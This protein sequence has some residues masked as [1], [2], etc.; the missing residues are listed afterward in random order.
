MASDVRY[1]ILIDGRPDADLTAELV[2][3]EVTESVSEATTARVR[4]AVDVCK[5]DLHFLDDSRLAP[6]VDR[7]LSVLVSVDGQSHIIAHGPIIDRKVKLL[8][9]GPGSW[10][11]V[12]A[13]DRRAVM[14]RG[15]RGE[16]TRSGPVFV[17]VQSILL[18]YGFIP[19]VDLKY[20]AIYTEFTQ[21]LNQASSDLA[22]IRLLAGQHDAQFWIDYRKT[23]VKVLETAHFKPS[24]K[25]SRGGPGGFSLKLPV[26]VEKPELRLN[27]GAGKATLFSFDAQWNSEV[28]NRS[29]RMARVDVDSARLER[30]RIDAPS[31]DLLGKRSGSVK[32]ES[33]VVSAGNLAEAHRR[34]TAALNDAA[35]NVHATGE[36]SVHLVCGL[37]RPH[38]V[39]KVVGVGAKDEGDYFVESVKHSINQA[40]HRMSLEL[41]RNAFGQ[42]SGRGGFGLGVGGF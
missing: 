2:E 42:R 27:S 23:P 9:G 17:I 1:Q 37:V 30:S 10:V 16:G 8:E 13:S 22:L 11:E 35:W 36:T 24:P 40:D 6:G 14:D 34:Q 28:P 20:T 25:G 39:V 33:Q 21:A 29:G 3:I 5:T 31:V 4:F 18:Q 12:T 38:E 32:I 26:L 7:L 15:A 19:D 41:R